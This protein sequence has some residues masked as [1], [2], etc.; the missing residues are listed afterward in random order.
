VPLDDDFEAPAVFSEEMVIL[1]HMEVSLSLKDEAGREAILEALGARHL[2]AMI[3]SDGYE[4]GRVGTLALLEGSASAD[5]VVSVKGLWRIRV[6]EVTKEGAR[7]RVRFKK[8]ETSKDSS[9]EASDLVTRVHGQVSEIAKLMPSVPHEVIS[10]VLGIDSPGELADVCG[11]SPLFDDKERM[12]LLETLE[13]TKR[14]LKVSQRLEKDLVSIRELAKSV[15]IP[16]CEICMDFADRALDSDGPVRNVVLAEFL[17]HVVE[18]HPSEM[19]A[20]IAEKY[21]PAFLRKRSLR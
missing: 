5:D 13:P 3:P 1:P 9:G 14:L 6:K 16:D 15:T 20:L 19:M 8:A 18:K 21:G 17:Q 10:F 7:P 12:D 11:G 2:V 4:V